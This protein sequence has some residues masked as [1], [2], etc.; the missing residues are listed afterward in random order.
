MALR[1]RGFAYG[2]AASDAF[3]FQNLNGPSGGI[4][5]SWN[6][7][8][9]ISDTRTG[10]TAGGGGEWKFAPNWSVKVEYL[11]YDLSTLS[12]NTL[13]VD[14]FLAGGVVAGSPAFHQCCPNLDPFQRQYCPRRRELLLQLVGSGSGRREVLRSPHVMPGHDID[15]LKPGRAAGFFVSR[16]KCNM[17]AC[18]PSVAFPPQCSR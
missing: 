15:P 9:N 2:Q 4:A 14:P 6:G 18:P 10:W 12:A 11:Y 13:V 1:T 16:A 5:T 8:A 7:A 3:F 17:A